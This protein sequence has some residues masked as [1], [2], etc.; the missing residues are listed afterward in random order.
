MKKINSFQ[1]GRV[2]VNVFEA[3]EG[4]NIV[5]INKSIIRNGRW[6]PTPFFSVEKGDVEDIKKALARYEESVEEVVVQ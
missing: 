6:E 2:W 5:T 1:S 4:Q 3:D